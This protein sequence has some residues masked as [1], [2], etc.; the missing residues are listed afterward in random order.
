MND[1]IP[2]HR[3]EDGE[4]PEP[5]VGDAPPK[6]RTLFSNRAYDILKYVAQVFLPAVALFYIAIAPLWGLPK[7]E[8]VAGTVV[9]LDLLL[10]TLLGISNKQYQNSDARFDGRIRIEPGEYEDTSNIGFSLDPDALA[11]K[12]EIQVKIDRRT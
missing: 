1:Y 6:A 5:V 7:Q 8:E 10:G 2:E 9:A 12:K 4:E 3:A 11:T